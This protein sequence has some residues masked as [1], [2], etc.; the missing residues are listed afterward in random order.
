VNRPG[1]SAHVGLQ[2]AKAVRELFEADAAGHAAQQHHR[3]LRTVQEFLARSDVSATMIYTHV[4]KVAAG[5]TRSPLDAIDVQRRE[6]TSWPDG[7]PPAG[8]CGPAGRRTARVEGRREEQLAEIV[9]RDAMIGVAR[10]TLT[11]RTNP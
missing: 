7:S 1:R 10:V 9:T 3:Q 6:R 5:G 4:L 8:H 11:V 2:I